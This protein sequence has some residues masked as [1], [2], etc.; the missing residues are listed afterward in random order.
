MSRIKSVTYA[1][2]LMGILLA[3]SLKHSNV[4]RLLRYADALCLKM[5]PEDNCEEISGSFA[6][7]AHYY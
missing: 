4:L 2:S 7:S 3:L 5:H 6:A 1:C